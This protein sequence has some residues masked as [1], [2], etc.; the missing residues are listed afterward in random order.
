MK[1]FTRFLP[2]GLLTV[3]CF[4]FSSY[5]Q[6]IVDNQTVIGHLVR[7]TPKLADIDRNSMYGKPFV[8]TRDKDGIIGIG[9]KMEE[10]EERLEEKLLQQFK[11]PSTGKM[12]RYSGAV[13]KPGTI[14]P[15]TPGTTLGVNFDGQT[16]PGLQPTDNNIA[17]GPNHV[18]QIVNNTAGSQFTIYNKSGAVVQPATILASI[19]GFT[20]FGDP[21]VLYDQLADRWLMSEFGAGSGG[22]G[23]PHRLQIAVSTSGNPTGSWK[24][25]SFEDLNFFI[26]YPKYS[27]WHNGYYA[28]SND[29]N[30]AGTS[31]LGS[32]VYSMD[33]SAML[34]G[35]ATATMIRTRL[36]DGGNNYNM[37]TIGL[38]GMTTSS[39][40]GLFAYPVGPSTMNVF[41]VTPDFIGGTQAVGPNTA[42]SISAFTAPPA[43]VPM[44]G[45]GTIQTLGQR[46]MFKL[47]YRN[48][49]GTESIV[50]THSVGNGAL[51][52]VR[53]YELRRVAGNWT[54][55]QQG[56]ITGSD[57]NSRFM[58]GISMDGQGNIALMYDLSG[59]TANPSVKYTA[60]NACDPLG[61]MTLPE[62]TIINASTG[63]GGFRWGDYNTTVQD[64]SAVGSPN[65]RSFWSTSQYGNQLTRIANYTITNPCA[66]A[67]VVA[68]GS[69]IVTE[70]CVPSNGVIDPVETVT[71]S[72]CLQNQGTQPTNNLV[73][74]LLTSGG[75]VT[76]SGP[77][78]YG[79]IAPG[80]TVCQSFSFSNTGI[81]GGTI[82]ATLQLQDG[83]SNLGTVTYNYTL[84]VL[85]ITG[86]LIPNGG[87][88]TGSFA[89]W[90][91]QA[92]NPTPVIN[93][94]APH[95]GTYAAF[96]G[97]NPGP[98]PLGDASF[99]QPITVPAGGGTL[100]FWFK[101]YTE[102]GIT[103]DW[104]DAYI[105]NAAGT[106]ILATIM[107]VCT[108]TAASPYQQM[109]YN[110]AAFA[111]QN[112]GVKFLV[113]QDGFGDVTSMYVD[114]VSVTS[115]S[116]ICC[117]APPPCTITCPG[118]ITVN[119]SPGQ[120][121]AN[122]NLPAAVLTG[123]CGAVT[124]SPAS[125]S[126]F[127]VG[128]TTVTATTQSGATCSFI[129]RVVDTQAPTVTCPANQVKSTDNNVCTYTTVG[130]QFDPTVTDNCPGAT[131]A[132]SLAGVTAGSGASLAGKVFNKG[133]TTVTWTATDAAGN[134]SSCSFTVTVNDTQ[135]PNI[136]CPGNATRATPALSCTYTASGTEFDATSSDNCPGVTQAYTLTGATAGTGN[137]TLAGKVFSI[138]TTTVSWK[139]TD[140]SGNTSVCTFT[141]LINDGNLPVITGQ[142]VNKTV[143]EGSNATF[144]VT[145]TSPGV[146]AYQ[147][148][149]WSG[150]AWGNIAGA[151]TSSYTVSN[152]TTAMNTNSFR[153]I[154][155]SICGNTVTSSFASL[156]VNKLPTIS[157][158][159]SRSP[160]LIP[161]QFV[162]ITANVVPT[163]GTIVW[164]KNG[165]VIT[166]YDAFKIPNLTVDDLGTY[167]ATYTDLNGCSASSG[168]VTLTAQP[169]DKL[170]VY[171]NPTTG[172]F[173]VRFY[174]TAGQ[175]V[176]VVIYDSRGAKVYQ[177]S[178]TTGQLAYS[179]IDVD[180]SKNASGV[181]VV[182]LMDSGGNKIS[183]KRFVLSH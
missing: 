34:A 15:Q 174:N 156:Y 116:Y 141:V 133:V 49:A 131:K 82:T 56:T 57:G 118:N 147:W 155:T 29:F 73:A 125:G 4:S 144:S 14:F 74:T 65:D 173:Q 159:T 59:S 134:T 69:S 178:L 61:Q 106:S 39:Q 135:N 77:Q 148:Q 107:H 75:V 85:N 142:P 98:E 103:F 66:G 152:T 93:T 68:N 11:D 2:V 167:D 175:Q 157:L 105:T 46:M 81:C 48:N 171:P 32:S 47:N 162:T 38:E 176:T 28:T 112:V 24:I 21:V 26:D 23:V 158:S 101:P 165:V 120:C 44:Q 58:G 182:D 55:Y 138:G 97:N 1:K 129:V 6:H 71:V 36:N 163:G 164:R 139:A 45:G 72:F 89:P 181:Y 108:G 100:S 137:N 60:R 88:E 183:T 10:T 91:I 109:T 110:L 12:L 78:T 13:Q 64:Y 149:Q 121:G 128:N 84:G 92:T 79:A 42:L 63:F 16:S 114:D 117:G 25:Y 140:A 126:A 67:L 62:A 50:M 33:R 160:A 168:S 161:G 143:C 9:A 113:H 31:Y 43:S 127:P 150:T 5:G 20:G 115:Q 35:A 96:L 130:T 104:Q 51:A 124:Y 94:T 151:T 54:V 180:L 52:A 153:V 27:V 177:R 170:F 166:G 136:S 122:V 102:D 86:G 8:I 83:A 123:S 90:V 80:A 119:N 3:L 111:G 172:Q 169:Y 17:V 7:V 154:L 95:T 70:G 53:W 18:I 87:F 19:T 30:N 76:P 22:G 132:Y 179:R 145:A 99:F 146:I 40:N 37:G 41:E